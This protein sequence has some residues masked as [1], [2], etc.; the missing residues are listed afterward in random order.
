M[1]PLISGLPQRYSLRELN[2]SL[3]VTILITSLETS[4]PKRLRISGVSVGLKADT[5][6]VSSVTTYRS[7]VG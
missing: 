1:R 5:A 2:G 3:P 7:K 6:A 4:K